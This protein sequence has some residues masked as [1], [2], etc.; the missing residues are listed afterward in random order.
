MAAS[1]A[2]CPSLS[3]DD[4]LY[5]CF[6]PKANL[7]IENQLPNV[8]IFVKENVKCTIGTDSLASNDSLSIWEE[9]QTIKRHYSEIPLEK[10]IQWATQNGA[11]FL[12]IEKD[13]GSFEV[14]K[15][16]KMNWIR[17]NRLT[18]L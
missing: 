10:L 11:E 1:V 6:C 17:G 7:Y 16:G 9:I 18:S 4:Y 2:S 5:W 12:G 15:L 14:G 13:Y 8:P 3:R